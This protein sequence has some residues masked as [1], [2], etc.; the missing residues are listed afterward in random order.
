MG[1]GH[2]VTALYELLPAGEPIDIPG[3]DALKYQQ[4]PA[5]LPRRSRT[6]R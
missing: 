3:V 4:P 5:W 6:R 1:A 2:S